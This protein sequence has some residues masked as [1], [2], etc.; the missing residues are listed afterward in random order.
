MTD[1]KFTPGPW[2]ACDRGDY[3]DFDGNSRVIIGDDTRIAVVHSR[4]EDWQEANAHLIASAT[5]LYGFS[6]VALAE[7]EAV[8]TDLRAHGDRVPDV[9][10][11]TARLEALVA[12][13]KSALAKARGEGQ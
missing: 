3:S 10:K 12:N 5:E 7:V 4:G 2:E 9:Q 6:S 8:L 1:T 13:G 11:E